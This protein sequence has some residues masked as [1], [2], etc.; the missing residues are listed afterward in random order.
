LAALAQKAGRVG[1][2]IL[3]LKTSFVNYGLVD[4]KEDAFATNRLP[5]LRKAFTKTADQAIKRL[6]WKMEV[7]GLEE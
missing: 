2:A 7:M 1:N 4:V 6:L 3:Q 5:E